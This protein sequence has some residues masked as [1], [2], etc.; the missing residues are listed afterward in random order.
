MS[1]RLIPREEKFFVD[2]QNMADQLRQGAEALV[3]M[4]AEDRPDVSRAAQIKEIEHECDF[5]THEIIQ[6]LHRTFVTPTRPRGHPRPRPVARRRDGRDRRGRP[7]CSASTASGQVRSG[8]RELARI[9]VDFA[10]RARFAQAMA[11]ARAR[12]GRQRAR[13]EIN[14]LENEADRDAPARRSAGC[15]RRSATRSPSSSGR[16]SSTSSRRRP[17][18]AR[19]S[20]TS[21]RASSSSTGR[22][23]ACSLVVVALIARRPRLRLHQ[24]LPR[25][26]QLD[27]HRRLDARAVAR[28]GGRLGGVLQLRRRLP[29][30]HGRR[31]DDRHR[32]DRHQRRHLRGDLRRAGRRD[33]LGP[34]HLVTSA[35]RPARRTR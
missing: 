16:R 18:A 13:V 7:G 22:A 6:R 11:G 34:D 24:R 19:T 27:R 31:E 26:G 17:T 35:C 12:E 4:L 30:R 15:S 21:S 2:F 1:F 32:D 8:A 29:V 20:R 28:P 9:I 23:D 5:I 3:A 33:R 10:A 25:R 14:R